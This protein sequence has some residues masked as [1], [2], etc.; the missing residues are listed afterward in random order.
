[1]R[2]PAGDR[3]RPAGGGVRLDRACG[4]DPGPV[5]VADLPRPTLLGEAVAADRRAP[6]SGEVPLELFRRCRAAVDARAV[7]P[8]RDTGAPRGLRDTPGTARHAVGGERRACR[9]R[10]PAVD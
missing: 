5:G 3:P 1:R 6:R 7:D 2:R 10:A 4:A 9:L 8:P